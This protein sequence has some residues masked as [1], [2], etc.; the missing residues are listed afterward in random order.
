MTIQTEHEK[1]ILQNF[2]DY[3]EVKGHI[4]EIIDC[5]DP[6]DAIV[7]IDGK[8]TFIELTNAFFSDSFE[9]S[10]ISA[11]NGKWKPVS[12]EERFTVNPNQTSFYRIID[13]IEKKYKE[14]TM[15]DTME[16]Y[17]KGTLIVGIYSPF[18]TGEGILLDYKDEISSIV[19]AQQ[20]KI[21]NQIYVYNNDNFYLVYPI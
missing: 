8:T 21:F 5:P 10:I 16:K 3:L 4:M 18:I 19:S 20:H 9:R 15:L 6:P 12:E 2:K 14:R 17:G 1:V 13:A 11:A 7:S